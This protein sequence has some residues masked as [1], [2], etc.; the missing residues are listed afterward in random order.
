MIQGLEHRLALILFYFGEEP[1]D[2]DRI[3]QLWGMLEFGLEF[4][5]RYK[6][7]LINV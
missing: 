7:K 3:A 5:G 2:F 6:K 1:T 4:E